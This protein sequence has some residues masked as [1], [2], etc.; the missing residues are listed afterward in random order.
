M[1]L[2]KGMSDSKGMFSFESLKFFEK[3]FITIVFIQDQWSF[4]RF[5][6]FVSFPISP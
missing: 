4:I 3:D 2:C 5:G 1:D 6:G